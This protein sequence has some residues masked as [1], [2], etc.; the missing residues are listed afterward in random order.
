MACSVRGCL[1][2]VQ[3]GIESHGS[4]QEAPHEQDDEGCARGGHRRGAGC[5]T[6]RMQQ[7]RRRRECRWR[8]A[9][10]PQYAKVLSATPI[11]KTYNNAKQDCHDET[12]T[13]HKP[14]KDTHQVAGTAIGAV[15][16]G[17]A[18]HQVGGGKRQDP[19]HGGR[20]G[21]RAA[22]PARR[23]RKSSRKTPPTPPSSRSARR[24]TTRTTKV[25]GYSVKY[26]LPD[27]TVKTTRMDHDP[28]DQG[29]DQA[30]HHGGIGRQAGRLS[31]HR[32]VSP[33]PGPHTRAI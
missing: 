2:D 16:G 7:E 4:I 21:G 28:G 12:V 13:H 20:R 9:Q 27:G 8:A 32:V 11:K 25:V 23:S 10:G 6:E 18:G 14:V 17:L 33:R 3:T 5:G 26:Q 22:M 30:V 29:R 15:V 19:G 24:S 31:E 1:N